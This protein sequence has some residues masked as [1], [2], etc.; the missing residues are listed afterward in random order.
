MKKSNNMKQP[1]LWGDKDK[2]SVATVQER[3][4]EVRRTLLPGLFTMYRD[5]PV[6]SKRY[7]K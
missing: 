3:A 6:Y 4:E 2:V 7:F 1:Y 5:T